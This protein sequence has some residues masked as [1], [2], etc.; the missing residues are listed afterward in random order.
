MHVRLAFAVA[1]YLEPEILIVDE[2]LAVGDSAFQKKCIGKMGEVAKGGRTVLF[3]SHSMASIAQICQTG[4]LMD[5]GQL[6]MHENVEAVVTKYLKSDKNRCVWNQQADIQML[7]SRKKLIFTGVRLLDNNNEPSAELDVRQPFR[8][9][10]IY[11]VPK[12]L[13]PVELAVRVL[14]AD[15]RPVM[16]SLCSES[17]P[18]TL[19]QPKHGVYIATATFPGMFLMPG[20]YTMNVAAHAAVGEV[21]DILPNVFSFAI[22]DT[23]TVFSKYSHNSAIGVVMKPLQWTESYASTRQQA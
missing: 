22:A 8:V 17:N 2:V 21:F 1:A 3:V 9:E 13:K 14:T 15:G 4:I 6:T 12:S 18:D 20:N 16:T 7:R 11:E 19:E 23:G 10:M 5:L